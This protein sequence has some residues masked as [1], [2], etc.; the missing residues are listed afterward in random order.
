MNIL[1]TGASSGIGKALSSEFCKEGN[2]R[3]LGVGRNIKGLEDVKSMYSDCFE[4]LVLDLSDIENVKSI[5]TEV[6][7]RFGVLDVL[8]NN[9]GYGLYKNLL[10]VGTN[11]IINMTLVNFIVP[12]ALVREL[13]PYM[14][15]GSVVVNIIT[16]GIHVLMTK[17][18]LYGATK[19]ALH[20]AS[21]ALRRELEV[22]DIHVVN[23]YPGYVETSFHVRAGV[24][25]VRKGLTPEEVA[26]HV[27]KS[28]K[29]RKKR[30]YVPSYLEI[31]RVFL[32]P[33]LLA[34]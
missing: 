16:A 20:Y 28:I 6:A 1:V 30:V 33:H 22:K 3:V 34:L 14:K 2:N 31:A 32:G 24:S 19:I 21:E 17:L 26:K 15:R 12:L 23:V 11:E 5:V 9:A 18:P 13:Q 8:V 4:Y 27:I 7:N 29:S 10:E 25:E